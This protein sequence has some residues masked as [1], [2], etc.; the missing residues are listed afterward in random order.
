[1]AAPYPFPAL[2]ELEID[3]RYVCSTHGDVEQEVPRL[4]KR[5]ARRPLGVGD[6]LM[7]FPGTVRLIVVPL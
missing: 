7:A 1:M 4:S 6:V 2:E 3:T 5:N